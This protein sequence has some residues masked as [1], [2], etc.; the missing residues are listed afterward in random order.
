MNNWQY[1]NNKMLE[2]KKVYNKVSKQTQNKL[3]E[4]FNSFNIDFNNLYNIADNKIK[5]R[6]NTYIEEWKDKG[7]LTG[8]FGMLAKS[9]YNR[10]RVKNSEI[11]ELLIYS[12]YIEE[13]NKLEETELNI[14]KD[15]VNYY[16]IQGQEEAIKAQEN[17]KEASIIPDAIFLSMLD[18]ANY[19][20]LTWKQHIET[21]MQYNAQQIYKQAII[22]IQQQKGLEIDSNE[23]Q[24][25]IQQQNRQKLNINGD[26]ISGAVDLN[27]IGLNNLAKVEGIKVFDKNAKVQ[28]ISDRCDNVTPMCMNMDRMIFNIN[29]WNEFIRYTGTSVKDIRQEKVRVFGLVKGVNAPP[30]NNFFHW[31]HSYIIYLPPVEKEDNIPKMKSLINKGLKTYNNK[32]LRQLAKETNNIANKYTTNKSKWSGKLII[33]NKNIPGKLWSCNIRINN[34]TAPHILLHEQL[35]AHSISYYD[36]DIYKKYADIEEATVQ[37]YTQE[38]SKKENIPIIASAYD[39]NVNILKEIN[40]KTHIGKD[41]FEFAKILFEKPVNQRI[42]FLEDRIYDIMQQGNIQEYVDLNNLLDKLR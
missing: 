20:G 2:L 23:F 4:I 18:M 37:L 15:D 9:I 39:E 26:K 28:F 24:R 31:C 41:N 29:D 36:K 1:H 32:E 6:L 10:T 5:N 19:N 27:L 38:I 21:T 13:Q 33:D 8:Y 14:I 40:N 17:K 12:A 7:L 34:E 35:H 25:I 42:D 16:Y 30:I 3:Q 22:N 11:L